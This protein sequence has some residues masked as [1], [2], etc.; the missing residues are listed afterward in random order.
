MKAYKLYNKKYCLRIAKKQNIIYGVKN[1]N[2]P[3]TLVEA[4][5]V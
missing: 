5:I 1:V 4:H 3:L 2:G